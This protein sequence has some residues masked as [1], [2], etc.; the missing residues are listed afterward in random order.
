[1][2]RVRLQQA[3]TTVARATLRVASICALL[4]GFAQPAS[5]LSLTGDLTVIQRQAPSGSGAYVGASS[6]SA[7]SAFGAWRGRPADFSI[8]Y[9]ATDSWAHIENPSWWLDQWEG[10]STPL[11]LSVPMLID[12]PSTSLQAGAIGAYDDHF[13]ALAQTLVKR[14]YA[15]SALRIGW[16]MNGSWYRW[17][18]GSDPSAWVTYYR[19]IVR[20]MRSVPGTA[21]QFSWNVNLGD[22]KLPAELVYPGDSYV[23]QVAVDA[24]D[25]QWAATRNTPI[26][27]WQYLT[28]QSHGLNWAATFA[29][30]HAKR[31][32]VPE[33]GLAPTSACS[34]GGGGDD[35]LYVR[36]MIAWMRDHNTAY[37]AYFDAHQFSISHGAFPSASPAYQSLE[38]V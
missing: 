21:F 18:A 1:M 35:P 14:G 2:Q 33:W 38:G 16:E 3:L 7:L 9:L 20:V 6:A 31:L 13:A 5:A 8:N 23:D 30:N 25:W 10:T 29:K 32:A 26:T 11:V 37:E 24:Y 22:N 12:D 28:G 17:S 19:R 34:G 27:R 15:R 36:N 4:W